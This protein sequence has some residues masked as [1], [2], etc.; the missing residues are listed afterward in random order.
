MRLELRGHGERYLCETL[1]L[2]FFPAAGF[3]D[4]VDD[5]LYA[6]ATLQEDTVSI[7]LRAHGR[8]VA[9]EELLHPGETA[10]EGI[11]R[12]FFR[13]GWALTGIKP[14]WG[15]LTGI[16]PAK[17]VRQLMDAGLTAEEAA[18]RLLRDCYTEPAKAMLCA[19]VLE[20]EERA[21]ARL[22]RKGVSIY[23]GIPFCPTRC[24]YCSF[25]SHSVE[26][27][28]RFI[29]SYVEALM[30]E[31]RATLAALR[32]AEIPVQTVYMG[33]GTPTTL[34]AEQLHGLLKLVG[35]YVDIGSLDEFTVEAGRPDTITAEKLQALI[36][37]GV[38]RISVNPQTTDNDTLLRIGRT[39]TA[40]EFFDCYHLARTFP[41]QVINVD[42]IAGLPGEPVA[43]FHKSLHDVIDLAP[44]NLTVHALS[45]KRAAR[46]EYKDMERTSRG[47]R[48]I[49]DMLEEAAAATAENNYHPY[50][51][52][53]QRN[54]LGN[55]E[56]VGYARGETQCLYNVYIMGEYQDIVALGAGGVSK[57]VG[58]PG[59]R[60][61][62]V[63]HNKHFHEYIA[64]REK[65]AINREKLL[66]LLKLKRS[67][68][69]L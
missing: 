3:S 24:S 11:G 41:F 38:D 52:Y 20:S 30:E 14:P 4:A 37:C 21:L 6:R 53:R 29:P 33:G 62:R 39:H 36:E 46:L 23:L 25:V 66:H 58:L 44:E 16:R 2:L 17:K 64:D 18:H 12:A 8:V 22:N 45:L 19:G 56:N 27:E 67:A 57:V 48:D 63:F 35:E 32:E 61:E 59:G 42:L 28:G 1:A 69:L 34:T 54:T 26:K 68:N 50:Y 15:T 49:F 60:I 43:A 47:A 51:L 9:A 7:T 5:G 31:T 10:G 55:L 65:L 13:A 40:E